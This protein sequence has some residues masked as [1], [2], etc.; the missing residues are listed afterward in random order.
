MEEKVSILLY[1]NQNKPI[2]EKYRIYARVLV[3]RKKSEF[4]I[5]FSARENEW[6][7]KRRKSTLAIIN[8]EMSDIESKIYKIRRQLIDENIPIT[9]STIVDHYKGKP[10]VKANLLGY[11]EDHVNYIET[12]GEYSRVT[13]GQYKTTQKIIRDF[14]KKKLK[15][16][17]IL[18]REISYNSLLEYDTYMV[19]NYTDPTGKH[20][21]RNTINKHHSRLRTVLNKAVREDLIIKSP[22]KNFQLKNKQTQRD[23]LT[24]KE[25]V[26]IEDLDLK[27]K[28]ALDRARDF[29]LFS[30]YTGLRFNDALSLKL[31]DIIEDNED[32]MYISIQMHKTKD[33]V[34]V[35]VIEDAQKIIDK[36]KDHADREVLGFILPQISNQK[37]N[38]HIKALAPLIKTRKTITHHVA[39][40]TFATIALNRGIPIEVVQKLLGHKDIHTTM[41][42]AKMLTKTL[43]REMEKMGRVK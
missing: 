21:E 12:R 8:E 32:R 29:F 20:I 15:K 24:E 10:G 6:D 19:K 37:L 7:Q 13:I 2:G 22:Y 3:N 43:V 33:L 5:G 1:L 39:R 41:I 9:A 25:L 26:Q 17:D 40:H 27:N 23:H 30:C 18:L 42:Y 4:S 35:P 28:P 16:Q 38:P 11:F 34:Q 14:L 31:D 36:Y